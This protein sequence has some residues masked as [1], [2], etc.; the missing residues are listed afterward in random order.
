VKRRYSNEDPS[1]PGKALPAV[2]QKF[3]IGR[4]D[5]VGIGQSLRQQ[6][7]GGLLIEIGVGRFLGPVDRETRGCRSRRGAA[8]IVPLIPRPIA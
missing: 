4:R 8:G 3:F 5:V 7:E 1:I 2:G 6:V